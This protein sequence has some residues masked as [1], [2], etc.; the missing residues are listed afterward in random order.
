[1]SAGSGWPWRA[2]T[3]ARVT[4]A[5]SPSRASQ[6]S[7][8]QSPSSRAY[9]GAFARAATPD[10]MP[11]PRTSRVASSSSDL[12]LLHLLMFIEVASSS[13]DALL[14]S[15][16]LDVDADCMPLVTVHSLLR[17]CE[18]SAAYSIPEAAWLSARGR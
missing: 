10:R 6:Y 8:R 4:G 5:T 17:G 11:A 3:R 16:F 1:M 13:F 7:A 18:A 9:S 2:A 12:L 15:A 14:H